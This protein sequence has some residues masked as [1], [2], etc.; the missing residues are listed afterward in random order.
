M[1][2]RSAGRKCGRCGRAIT[3]A[4]SSFIP[5]TLHRLHSTD[6]AAAGFPLTFVRL[7]AFGDVDTVAENDCMGVGLL[8]RGN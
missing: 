6:Y 4:L 8:S 2:A 1:R 7:P 5:I 3:N